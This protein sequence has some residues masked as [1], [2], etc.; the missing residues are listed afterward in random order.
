MCLCKFMLYCKKLKNDR[1]SHACAFNVVKKKPE[2]GSLTK[3]HCLDSFFP[4]AGSS[5][6]A[7]SSQTKRL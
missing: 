2:G 3:K 5:F 6:L 4:Q 1:Y 7:Q